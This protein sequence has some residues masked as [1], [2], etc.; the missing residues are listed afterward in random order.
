MQ[1][2][3]ANNLIIFR[4]KNAN[5]S[6]YCFYVNTNIWEE[7]QICINVPLNLRAKNALLGIF[8]PKIWK[9]NTIFASGISTLEFAKMQKIVQNKKN[10]ICDQNSLF[11][12][13]ELQVLKGI[14]LFE[15]SILQFVKMKRFV[16]N[17]NPLFLKPKMSNLHIFGVELKNT[18]I[19]FEIC[20]FEFVLLQSLVQIQKSWK[21]IS[22]KKRKCLNL[23]P[24]MPYLDI[25]C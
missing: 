3:L 15:I 2:T 7:F 13:F 12:Y 25:F 9:K 17:Q 24:T 10:Q 16:Q 1:T 20:I 8:R 21:K 18:I 5:F 11:R 23:A 14:F 22:W 4:I 19:I 6:I